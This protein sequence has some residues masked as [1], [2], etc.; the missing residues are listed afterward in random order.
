MIKLNEIE[1]RTNIMK[2]NFKDFRI[3]LDEVMKIETEIKDLE[4][5][6]KGNLSVSQA[7]K[8]STLKEKKV[9]VERIANQNTIDFYPILAGECLLLNEFILSCMRQE[10]LDDKELANLKQEYIKTE[11][12]LLQLAV[13]HDKK[14]ANKLDSMKKEVDKLGFFELINDIA[15]NETAKILGMYRPSTTQ[16]KLYDPEAYKL[17][18]PYGK[19]DEYMEAIKPNEDKKKRSWFSFK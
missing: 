4:A 10:I 7:M 6:G 18:F 9:E 1:Q 15:S 17:G 5:I 19:H 12:K 8:L 11:E 3:H 14:F 16:V 13:E 2:K